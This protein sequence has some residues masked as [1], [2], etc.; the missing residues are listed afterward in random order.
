M[1]VTFSSEKVQRYERAV[2]NVRPFQKRG[3]QGKEIWRKS[4]GRLVFKIFFKDNPAPFSG[5]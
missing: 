5:L 1:R 4:P 2:E 3:F